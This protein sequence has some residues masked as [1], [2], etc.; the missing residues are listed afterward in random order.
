MKKC[1]SVSAFTYNLFYITLNWVLHYLGHFDKPLQFIFDE[2][3][4]PNIWMALLQ[5]IRVC[6]KPSLSC[7]G[8]NVSV[9]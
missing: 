2:L 3:D 7:L 5:T 1:L 9:S 4:Y 8:Q 6:L